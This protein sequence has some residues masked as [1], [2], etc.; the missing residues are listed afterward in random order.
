VRKVAIKWKKR[1]MCSGSSEMEPDKSEG[2]AP[3]V[4]TAKFV[5]HS[6]DDRDDSVPVGVRFV[7]RMDPCILADPYVVSGWVEKRLET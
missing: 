5:P 6:D 3:V 7:E 2:E 1:D 4:R